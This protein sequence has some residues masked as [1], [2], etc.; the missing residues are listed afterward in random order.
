MKVAAAIAG[1]FSALLVL[2]IA[3]YLQY[4]MLTLVPA[5]ELMWFLFWIYVPLSFLI[6]FIANVLCA[7]D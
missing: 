6:H 1:L 5:T 3:F 4:K 2:P 7:K